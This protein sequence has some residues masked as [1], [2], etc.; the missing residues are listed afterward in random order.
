MSSDFESVMTGGA[1]HIGNCA[2]AVR[3]PAGVD[4]IHTS[5]TPGLRA[6]GTLPGDFGEEVAQP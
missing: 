6:D 3:I 4:T 5:G 1:G 2:D